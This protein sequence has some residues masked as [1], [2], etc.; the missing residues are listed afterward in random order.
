MKTKQKDKQEPK[1]KPKRK[2]DYRKEIHFTL[3]C[4]EDKEVIRKYALKQGLNIPA[5][6]RSLVYKEV[7]GN[8]YELNKKDE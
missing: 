8:K 2:K 7:F 4:I 3:F 6:T 1:T 5:F